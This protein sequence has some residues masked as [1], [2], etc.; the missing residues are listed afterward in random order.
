MNNLRPN[1]FIAF[2]PVIYFRVKLVLIQENCVDK[3]SAIKRI[4][5]ASYRNKSK[6]VCCARGAIYEIANQIVVV[7]DKFY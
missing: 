4:D 1:L 3:V 6:F 7:A 2:I 5:T